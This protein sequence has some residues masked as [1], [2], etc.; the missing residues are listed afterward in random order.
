MV[1]SPENRRFHLLPL[2][3]ERFRFGE[4]PQALQV[5]RDIAEDLFLRDSRGRPWLLQG[6]GYQG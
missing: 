5:P 3:L 2:P 1:F 6:K 4:P